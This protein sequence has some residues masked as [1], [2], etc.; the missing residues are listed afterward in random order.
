MTMRLLCGLGCFAILSLLAGCG[1]G[2]GI[3]PTGTVTFD[4]QSISL[5]EKGLIVMHLIK[6]SDATAADQITV[7]TKQ[8]GSFEVVGRDN[9]GVAPGKYRVAIQIFDPY[10]SNDLL[11]G[12]YSAT[13]SKL[14]IDVT[15]NTPIKVDVPKPTG[16]S[17]K[18]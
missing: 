8:D 7:N 11:N 16:G 2:G 6:E 14:V 4:G 12:E 18:K 3:K 1:G 17:K 5:G 13:N 9:H 10:P 15:K